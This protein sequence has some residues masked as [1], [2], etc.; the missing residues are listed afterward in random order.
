MNRPD[1][2]GP[3]DSAHSVNSPKAS[4]S[5]AH[6]PLMRSLGEFFGHIKKAVKTDPS[7]LQAQRRANPE[8]TRRVVSERVEER[9]VPN[10]DGT[11]RMILRRTVVEEVE[12]HPSTASTPPGRTEATANQSAGDSP[13]RE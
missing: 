3:G 4:H 1:V 5:A 6:K 2:N 11:G 10:P 13:S 7:A 12:I 9:E 8:P